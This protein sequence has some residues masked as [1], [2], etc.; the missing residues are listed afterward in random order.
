MGT[1]MQRR[2]KIFSMASACALG[3][4]TLTVLSACTPAISPDAEVPKGDSSSSMAYDG[5]APGERYTI[6]EKD[7]VVAIVRN[8]LG[9]MDAMESGKLSLSEENCLAF[10]NNEGVIIGLT[11]PKGFTLGENGSVVTDSGEIIS[12]GTKITVGGGPGGF[13]AEVA[14]KA[15]NCQDMGQFWAATD[16]SKVVD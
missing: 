4:S 12:Q 6:T 5:L 7:G 15:Q 8:Y 1:I 9:G 10:E 14:N 16:V 11:L 2:M 3:I 13:P